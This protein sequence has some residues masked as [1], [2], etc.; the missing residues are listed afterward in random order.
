MHEANVHQPNGLELGNKHVNVHTPHLML[1]HITLLRYVVVVVVVAAVIMRNCLFFVI[2]IGRH[3]YM[4]LLYGI[5][6]V[7]RRSSLDA[8]DL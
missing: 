8:K 6:P 3:C 1:P 2:S 4:C 5:L 7:S